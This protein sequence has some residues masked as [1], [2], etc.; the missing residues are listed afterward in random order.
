MSTRK[1][2]GNAGRGAGP[3]STRNVRRSTRGSGGGTPPTSLPNGAPTPAT[4]RLFGHSLTD[5]TSTSLD[6]YDQTRQL[7]ESNDRLQRQ[8]A[9]AKAKTSDLVAAVERAAADAATALRMPASPARP[10]ARKD[11]SGDE[12]KAIIVVSDIQL[13]KVTPSYSTD[14]AERRVAQLADKVVALTRIQRSDHPVREARVYLLGDIVEGELI[15]SHQP[16]QVDASLYRQVMVDGPRILTT[17]LQKMLANFERVH[18]VG[19]IGN[20]GRFGEYKSR[21]NPETNADRMLYRFV[22]DL[23]K[24]E[25]RLTWAIPHMKNERAWYAVDYPFGGTDNLR[26]EFSQKTGGRI[27]L[28]AISGEHHG[29]LLF[30]GDQIRGG[31]FAGFPFYGTAKRIWGW[32]NGAIPEP[33]Q[34][35]IFGHWHTPTRMT[36]NEITVWANGTTESTNTYA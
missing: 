13:A 27:G 35:A 31:G 7:R 25:P 20:H 16:W 4:A 2:K 18:V 22:A 11:S 17:F 3:V 32:R 10:A 1:H 23:F 12:E 21:Y 36:L 29:F 30:H 26:A 9:Q 8:L 24:N 34:Y 14:V 5:S 6:A 33:F 28:K 19:V 15:F